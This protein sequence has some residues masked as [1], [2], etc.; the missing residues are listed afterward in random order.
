MAEAGLWKLRGRLSEQVLQDQMLGIVLPLVAEF[1]SGEPAPE[2]P[3]S[4]VDEAS[5]AEGPE[6]E[7]APHIQMVFFEDTLL[8]ISSDEEVL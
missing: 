8:E 4:P 3:Q 6:P 7:E 5:I 1:G 2:S